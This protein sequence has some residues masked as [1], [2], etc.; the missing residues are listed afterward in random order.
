MHR[1]LAL[2]GHSFESAH[3]QIDPPANSGDGMMQGATT[4]GFGRMDPSQ[5]DAYGK[6]GVNIHSMPMSYHQASGSL[7]TSPGKHSPRRLQQHNIHTL[8]G[9]VYVGGC[10]LSM[11]EL[12]LFA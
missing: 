2:R 4:G 9:A 5:L 7:G 3:Q 11:V 12:P 8:A 10:I 1:A 6:A